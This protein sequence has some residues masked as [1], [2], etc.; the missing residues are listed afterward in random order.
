MPV[1]IILPPKHQLRVKE[2]QS[3]DLP[4]IQIV[5]T[6]SNIPH[7]SRIT[8]SVKGTPIE[9]AAEIQQTYKHFNS[10][11]PQK[12]SNLCQL[13]QYPYQLEKPLNETVNCDLQVIVE[14][15]DSDAT[16]KPILSI[17]K[18][19][20]V[21]CNLWFTPDFQSITHKTITNHKTMNPF[22]LDTYLNKLSQ[23]LS[24]KLNEKPK[25]RFPGWFAVDFGTSN[26]TVTLFDPIE[27]PI[28]EVLP[29][30]QELRLRQRLAE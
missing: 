18:N 27:V 19:M 1:E 9:L 23:Q 2:N 7:I 14:Y 25:K 3:L 28:A 4:A 24:E 15:F 29:R 13:G 8:C 10:A 16:G 21:S 6:N 12:I 26:S 5:A 30:E 11:T 20:G 22:E 17:K